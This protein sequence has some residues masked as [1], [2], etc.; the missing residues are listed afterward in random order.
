[1]SCRENEKKEEKDM[2]VQAGCEREGSRFCKRLVS[3]ASLPYSMK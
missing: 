1:M 3:P 2:I